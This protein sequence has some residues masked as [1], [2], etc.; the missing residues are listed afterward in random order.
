MG[1][2]AVNGII[3]GGVAGGGVTIAATGAAAAGGQEGLDPEELKMLFLKAYRKE[4]GF[5]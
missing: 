1:G 4:T 3:A 2:A 5:V